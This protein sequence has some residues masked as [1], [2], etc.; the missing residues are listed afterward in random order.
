[1]VRYIWY[2]TVRYGMVRY[3]TVRYGMVRYGSVRFGTVQYGSVRCGTSS[4]PS[5]ILVRYEYGTSTVRVRYEYDRLATAYFLVR[6]TPTIRKNY[7]SYNQLNTV[8]TIFY[9]FEVL[10]T[11]IDTKPL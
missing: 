9:F 6:A 7:C 1:M 8:K 11:G 2:G 5:T 4:T 3:G 10:S